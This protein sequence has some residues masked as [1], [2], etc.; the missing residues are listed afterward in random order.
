MK[1]PDAEPFG[2]QQIA[3][4]SAARKREVEMKLVHPAHEHEIGLR[5][6]PGQVIHAAP[7]DAQRRRLPGDR[8]SV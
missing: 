2:D 6:Q 7:A 1:T 3:Q 5:D 8:Q 4:H